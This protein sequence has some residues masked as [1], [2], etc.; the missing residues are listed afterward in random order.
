MKD[1]FEYQGNVSITGSRDAAREAFHKGIVI[2]G[3]IWMEMIKSRN[4]TSH[5]YN[6]SVAEEIVDKI[7][8]HYFQAFKEFE[9]KMN[10]LLNKNDAEKF[11]L[12]QEIIQKINSV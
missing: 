6:K 7:Q 9:V 3:D 1:Y 2:N 11:G 10:T 4:K 5:T 12:S 8:H